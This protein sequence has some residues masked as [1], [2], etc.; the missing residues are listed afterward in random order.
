MQYNLAGEL[1]DVIMWLL[2]L[3]YVAVASKSQVTE[4][5]LV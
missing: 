3:H 2:H 1:A 4:S 5:N